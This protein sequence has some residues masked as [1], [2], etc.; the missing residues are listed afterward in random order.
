MWAVVALE[1]GWE[2]KIRLDSLND[3]EPLTLVACSIAMLVLGEAFGGH[4][5]HDFWPLDDNE[6]DDLPSEVII[7]ASVLEMGDYAFAGCERIK[8]I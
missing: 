3:A 2:K 5:R 4:E 6:L 1:K 8:E 7:P